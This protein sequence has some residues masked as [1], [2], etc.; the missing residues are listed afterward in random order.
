MLFK[1]AE[2]FTGA[3]FL[4]GSFRTEH[5]IFTEI[6]ASVPDEDGVE[7]DGARVIPGLIDLHTHGNS[8]WR[9]TRRATASPPSRRLR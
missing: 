3:G 2:I 6:L 1:N 9:P 7:L 8:R 4:R 5:G